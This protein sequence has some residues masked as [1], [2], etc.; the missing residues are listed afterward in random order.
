MARGHS[1]ISRLLGLPQ[2]RYTADAEALSIWG[3]DADP[4][5][6]A[7]SSTFCKQSSVSHAAV[8]Y[9]VRA[10]KGGLM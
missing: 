10:I 3:L 8:I 7:A 6:V 5:K 9:G 2:T 1:S 4:C